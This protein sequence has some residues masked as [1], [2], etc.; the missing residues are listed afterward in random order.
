MT[1]VTGLTKARMLLMEAAT[2]VSGVVVGDNLILTKN[3]A[4]TVNAGNVR[5]LTGAPGE[6][7][8]ASLVA[9]LANYAT[10]AEVAALFSGFVVKATYTPTLTGMAIGTGGSAANGGYYTYI[11]GPSVGNAGIM[12]AEGRVIFGTSGTTFPTSPTISLP[13]GFNF[14]TGSSSTNKINGSAAF[15]DSGAEYDGV[16]KVSTV[17]TFKPMC[18]SA[19]TAYLTPVNLTALIPFTFGAG[20]IIDWSFVASVIRV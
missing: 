15:N 11:G 5:G 8:N 2:I 14:Q 1:T 3:D 18:H 13:A 16:L 10:D 17:S 6:V 9:T 7:T 12:H 19:A 4:S 20:D